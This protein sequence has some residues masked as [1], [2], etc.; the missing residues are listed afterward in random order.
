LRKPEKGDSKEATSVRRVLAVELT[1][2]GHEG[3]HVAQ[4]IGR[5][6]NNPGFESV[7]LEYDRIKKVADTPMREFCVRVELDLEAVFVRRS[8]QVV[9]ENGTS[10]SEVTEGEM[11]P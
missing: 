5:L 6:E 8:I 1:G 3:V 10:L 9:D 7:Q 2:L 4:L 11:Q